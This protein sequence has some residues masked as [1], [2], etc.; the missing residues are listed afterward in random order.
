MASKS[1]TD[2]LRVGVLR[3]NGEADLS[4]KNQGVSGGKWM[5]SKGRVAR[6]TPEL[7]VHGLSEWDDEDSLD[8]SAASG[9][10]LLARGVAKRPFPSAAP[11]ASWPLPSL[12]LLP[13][14]MTELPGQSCTR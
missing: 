8:P 7:R 4:E 13:A 11:A 10:R 5:R 14:G 9:G 12:R 3:H 2:G 6:H 1:S